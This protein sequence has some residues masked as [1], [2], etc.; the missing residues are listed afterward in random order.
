MAGT[1][2]LSLIT[3]F[4]P[5]QLTV[6][7]QLNC[8]AVCSSS[9]V[10]V[11][12]ALQPKH[13]WMHG[14]RRRHFNGLW[15]CSSPDA[16]AHRVSALNESRW[17]HNTKI[18]IWGRTFP[19]FSPWGHSLIPPVCGWS[20]WYPCVMLCRWPVIFSSTASLFRSSLT[21][22]TVWEIKAAAALLECLTCAEP[23]PCGAGDR[24]LFTL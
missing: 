14:W 1:V 5:N 16:S 13:A 3:V 19:D 10:R 2:L 20:S 4:Q 21:P 15:E 12:R 6:V 24:F 23:W 8:E 22:F 18:R 7:K 17:L 11:M 9:G